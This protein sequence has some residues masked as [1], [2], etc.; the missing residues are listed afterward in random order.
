[1]ELLL[2]S[3]DLV[4]V[5]WNMSS[6]LTKVCGATAAYTQKS[7]Y[8]ASCQWKQLRKSVIYTLWTK[9]K[10]SRG[11]GQ[12]SL[13]FKVVGQSKQRGMISNGW[14]IDW[15]GQGAV[16]ADSAQC[17]GSG[18]GVLCP[19]SRASAENSTDRKSTCLTLPELP[20]GCSTEP[21]KTFYTTEVHLQTNGC[22]MIKAIE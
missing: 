22:S 17:H 2:Y 18:D 3:L 16:V 14:V 4:L 19:L 5:K 21:Q 15:S 9:D 8:P 12:K 11:L 7:L 1:M 13:N 6:I 10:W 20:L